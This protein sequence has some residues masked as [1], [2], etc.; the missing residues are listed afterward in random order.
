MEKLLYPHSPVP[1]SQVEVRL[2]ERSDVQHFSTFTSIDHLPVPLLLLHPHHPFPAP[3]QLVLQQTANIRIRN[4]E[5]GERERKGNG[6]S[7]WPDT[8]NQ[9]QGNKKRMQCES[10]TTQKPIS[11]PLRLRPDRDQVKQSVGGDGEEAS[12]SSSSIQSK[13]TMERRSERDFSAFAC[14]A[15]SLRIIIRRGIRSKHSCL[16]AIHHQRDMKPHYLRTVCL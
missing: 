6:R 3:W 12:S 5:E 10:V 1:F 15:G 7:V 8:Q 9:Q 16:H 2:G 13:T 14:T 4:R 11:C